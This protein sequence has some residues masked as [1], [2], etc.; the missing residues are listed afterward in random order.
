ML[1]LVLRCCKLSYFCH[2]RTNNNSVTCLTKFYNVTPVEWR[3]NNL[4]LLGYFPNLHGWSSERL[5]PVVAIEYG[6][7]CSFPGNAIVDR[8]ISH[9]VS[10]AIFEFINKY[11]HGTV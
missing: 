10:N 5:R 6:L 3:I 11:L 9:Y 4:F 8:V 2:S 1:S 7:I